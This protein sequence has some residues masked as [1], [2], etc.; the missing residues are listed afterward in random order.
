[1]ILSFN[2]QEVQSSAALPP[3]VG[4]IRV[5]EQVRLK[6]MR[7]GKLSTVKVKIGQLPDS[8]QPVAVEAMEKISDGVLG[9]DVRPLTKDELE[10]MELSHGLQVQSVAEGAAKFAGIR[11]GDV[12]QL[13]N[14]EK[15]Q[16]VMGLK[17]IVEKLPK[18][19]FAS[20]L[21][22]RHQGPQFLAL[23]IPEAEEK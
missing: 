23:K 5:G 6:I 16:T 18:G 4:R 10:E 8:D 17:E 20:I 3:M 15:V 11:K 1:V 12:L 2:G 22:Q 7:D 21:V 13:I 14:G 9:L 19:K